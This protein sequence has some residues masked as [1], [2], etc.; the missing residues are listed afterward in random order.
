MNAALLL[1]VLTRAVA[2]AL[3]AQGKTEYASLLNDLVSAASAGHNVDALL[4]EIAVEW[5]RNGEPSFEEI[6]AKR[7][8]IKARIAG[9]HI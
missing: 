8:Q 6:A 4:A 9:G 1:P 7:Q 5:D 3:G 2:V